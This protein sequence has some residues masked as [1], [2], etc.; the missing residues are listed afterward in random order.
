MQEH[1]IQK[2]SSIYRRRS[3][4]VNPN[5]RLAMFMTE[6]ERGKENIEFDPQEKRWISPRKT[7]TFEEPLVK[8]GWY[9]KHDSFPDHPVAVKY[10]SRYF[11]GKQKIEQPQTPQTP[12]QQAQQKLRQQRLQQQHLRQQ[13]AQQRLQQQQTR[14]RLA[15]QQ[16]QQREERQQMRR[17]GQPQQ[18]PTPKITPYFSP[19][20]KQA[21]N[22]FLGKTPAGF[23][24]SFS[25]GSRFQK[26]K[27]NQW[28][29]I[30]KNGQ[31]DYTRTD[32]DVGKEA[33]KNYHDFI[34]S[35][36]DSTPSG[37]FL[38]YTPPSRPAAAHRY[39]RRIDQNQ[40]EDQLENKISQEKM[41]VHLLRN[42]KPKDLLS[43]LIQIKTARGSPYFPS[44]PEKTVQTPWQSFRQRLGI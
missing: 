2:A 19:E 10:H 9:H 35:T 34:S 6:I 28:L 8:A 32:D 29:K 16:L 21:T 39:F 23:N 20:D 44:P 31:R 25:D 1:N 13:L 26:I 14:Q 24:F 3:A 11:A 22:T 17:A 4:P 42:T 5:A 43:S 37:A 41:K 36:L 40:W 7:R 30:D 12:Q 18:V 27:E 33:V 15:Q 38:D